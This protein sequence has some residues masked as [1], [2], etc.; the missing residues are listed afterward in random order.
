MYG[1]ALKMLVGDT[2]KYIGI[3]FGITFAALIMTQQPA[4]FVGLMERTFSLITDVSYPQLWVMD[5]KV[6]YVDDIKPMQDTKLL[7]VRGVEGVAWAVPFFKGSVRAR[8]SD[9]KFQN[10]VM[11]GL[12][13][14]TLIGGPG[15]MLSGKLEDLRH[16]DAIIVDRDGAE[17]RLRRSLPDGTSR[18]LELGDS[19]EINDRRAVVVGIARTTRSFQSQPLIYTTY[20][21]AIQFSPAERLKL[22]FILAGVTTGY[23]VEKVRL[24]INNSTG[25][26]ARTAAEFKKM[27]LDYFLTNT[28]IPINF[29]ISV[30]LGFLVGAAIAGQMFFN[31]THDNIR[32][33]GALKAMG[34]SNGLLTRMIMLQALL[35]GF[36]GW[37]LGVGLAALFG[38]SMR[39]S[40]LAFR[41]VWE[42]LGLS[43]AGVLLIVL[44]AALISI[45]KVVVLEPA[46]VFK[47]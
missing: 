29:G 9:G 31:F 12:D 10:V 46:I 28:G 27:T 36:T 16:T 2:S 44:I 3:I 26:I 41:L 4:I 5:S 1:V 20:Q 38:Y 30:G 8:T 17:K 40:I 23:D 22:S 33:F 15:D 47:G 43:G 21:R 45:R 11:V 14:A 24:A 37:G 6:Q 25:L 34:A 18:P 32:Q 35:S 42:I 19:L 39:H 7:R 13:D